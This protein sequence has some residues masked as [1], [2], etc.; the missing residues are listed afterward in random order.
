[1]MEAMSCALPCVL[2]KVKG[3]EDLLSGGKCG[4]LVP[5]GDAAALAAAVKELRPDPELRRRLGGQGAERIKE[6]TLDAVLPQ[7]LP[8]FLKGRKA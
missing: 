6:Y 8:W 1:M 4:L 7:V 3:H 2:S 5:Y